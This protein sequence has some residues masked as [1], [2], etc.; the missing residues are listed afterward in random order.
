MNKAC[1]QCWMGIK[2]KSYKGTQPCLLHFMHGGFARIWLLVRLVVLSSKAVMFVLVS[3]NCKCGRPDRKLA[4]YKSVSFL[5]V[6]PND[7]KELS[8]SSW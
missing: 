6:N 8:G 2:L 1:M 5:H 4:H 7:E 3:Y